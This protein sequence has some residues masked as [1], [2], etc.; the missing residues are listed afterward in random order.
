[1]Y[2]PSPGKTG[3]VLQCV[4]RPSTISA[5]LDHLFDDALHLG[6]LALMGRFEPKMAKELSEK[7]C[8]IVQRGSYV[9]AISRHPKVM[10]ALYTGNAFFTRMEGEWWTRL[11]G[12][13]F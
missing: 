10:E 11:Q 3:Q 7:L 1:M 6:S 9:Q 13:A 4:G 12:D 5:V 8:I 2:Y